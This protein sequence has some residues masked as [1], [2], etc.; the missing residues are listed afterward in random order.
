[1]YRSTGNYHPMIYVNEFWLQKKHLI[2]LNS[3]V[4]T[5]PLE[6]SVAPMSIWK[7]QVTNVSRAGRVVYVLS[8]T[9]M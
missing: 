9:R 4:E 6:L 2:E 7:F 8:S 3:T 5:L 1:M